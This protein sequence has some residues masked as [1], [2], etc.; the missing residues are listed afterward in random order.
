MDPSEHQP[1]EAALCELL[2]EGLAE[3]VAGKDSR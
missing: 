3:I 2:A 1:S